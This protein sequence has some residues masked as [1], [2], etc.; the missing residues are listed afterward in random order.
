[1]ECTQTRED[2]AP[3]PTTV[4]SLGRVTRGVNF[5][6]VND[7]TQCNFEQLPLTHVVE[8]PV[9]FIVQPVR[10]ARKQAPSPTEHH[11]AQ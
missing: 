5:S 1:M 7:K 6:L 8:Y 9:Q 11:V 4:T 3:K 10:E 2:T